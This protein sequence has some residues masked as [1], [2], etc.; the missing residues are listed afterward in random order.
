[1]K[2]IRMEETIVN[3]M[4]S[5]E[6]KSIVNEISKAKMTQ[7]ERMVYYEKKYPE[8][9]KNYSMLFNMA[10]EPGFELER[11]EYMMNMRDRIINKEETLDSASTKV[12]QVLFDKFVKPVIK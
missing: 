4:S 7:K 11:F 5:E 6:I 10:C 2:R 1:M 12:G 9:S 8:F 3:N